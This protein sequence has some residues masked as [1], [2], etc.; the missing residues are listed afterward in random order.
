MNPSPTENPNLSFLKTNVTSWNDLLALFKHAK[1]LHSR[2]DHVFSNAGISGRANYLDESFDENGEL[3]EPTTLTYDINLRGMVNTSY[4]GLYHMRHQEPQG[5]SIVCTGSA[6]SIQRFEALDYTSAKH[7]VLGWM[8]GIIPVLEEQKIPIRINTIAP[9]WTHTKIVG[10]SPQP[11]LILQRTLNDENSDTGP[12][13]Q[14]YRHA[15]K[16]PRRSAARFPP[17]KNAIWVY[18][19]LLPDVMPSGKMGGA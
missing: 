10:V 1:Q 12:W 17:L 16:R 9:S 7:G 18:T 15:L 3:K 4:L 13:Y 5:G 2:I 8:R 11:C 14:L 6:A 19:Y